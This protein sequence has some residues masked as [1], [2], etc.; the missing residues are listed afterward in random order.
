M[1]IIHCRRWW[2]AVLAGDLTSVLQRDVIHR[3]HDLEALAQGA[4]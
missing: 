1:F 4:C 3:Q 2:D